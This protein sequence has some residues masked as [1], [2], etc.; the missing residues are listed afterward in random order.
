MAKSCYRAGLD[1]T[2]DG[3]TQRRG[4]KTTVTLDSLSPS[5]ALWGGANIQ[6]PMLG[7]RNPQGWD[8]AHLEAGMIWD[9]TGCPG[10]GDK[11]AWR[12]QSPVL[13]G[14]MSRWLVPELQAHCH[15]AD[16]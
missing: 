7:R 14:V 13:A 4:G 6:H 10:L 8:V 9:Y 11:A 15:I 16:E 2:S 12:N 1:V 5:T 3:R